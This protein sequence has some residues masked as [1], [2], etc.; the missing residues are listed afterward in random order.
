MRIRRRRL[1]STCTIVNKRASSSPSVHDRHGTITDVAK[2]THAH[3]H[4]RATLPAIAR[5]HHT[6]HARGMWSPAE[7][8]NRKRTFAHTMC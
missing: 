8:R 6:P 1:G 2:H 7:P 5:S 4:V 3:T